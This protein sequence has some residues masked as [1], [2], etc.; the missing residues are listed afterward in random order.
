MSNKKN[1]KKIIMEQIAANLLAKKKSYNSIL[2]EQY[3]KSLEENSNKEISKEKDEKEETKKDKIYITKQQFDK[4][5]EKNK[6][7]ILSGTINNSDNY[8]MVDKMVE[9]PEEQVA[10]DK[11][12]TM[13]KGEKKYFAVF[14]E[15]VLT[16]EVFDVLDE[17]IKKNI[18]E[19]GEFQIT[20]VLDEVRSKSG[21]VAFIP[22][23]EML[24]VGNV[25]SYKK[26]FIK[27]SSK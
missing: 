9:K 2:S 5:V 1:S 3:I 4:I 17:H 25:K 14:G 21:M 24:D 16:K 20:S 6:Y 27:K 8:Y 12:Y 18:R 11:Y 15:Y 23:G 7:G 26:T 13:Y 22:D 19:N 10:E